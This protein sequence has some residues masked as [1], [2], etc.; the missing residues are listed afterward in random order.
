M[1]LS[2]GC[3]TVDHVREEIDMKHLYWIFPDRGS[4]KQ[5]AQE[6]QY[7]WDEYRV[8]AADAGL[9]LQVVSP[10]AL[11]IYYDG[12]VKAKVFVNNDEV[13]ATDTIFVTELYTF[14]YHQQDTL[15]Q[16]TTFTTLALLG[17]YLPISPDLSVIMN[18]KLATYLFFKG[19]ALPILPSARITTGRDLDN[20]D[21][22]ILLKEIGLPLVIKPA[23]WG[24]GMGI[25][26]AHDMGEVR[27]ILSLAS[28]SEATM[29]IQPFLGS[30][31]VV[32]YRVYFVDG[33]PH[34]YVTRK[35]QAGEIIAN[36]A[37]GGKADIIENIP[38]ELVQTARKAGEMIRLPYFCVDFLF[39]GQTFWLSEV[40][41]DGAIASQYLDKNKVIRLL[42]DRFDAYN[43]SHQIWITKQK[44]EWSLQ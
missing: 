29:L 3:H 40:E 21:L 14:P 32:D 28:G 10:E 20:H 15:V 4:T 43:R 38:Q 37:R 41:L 34:T 24:S 18:D 25:N 2:V 22:T 1:L 16:M 11:S 35:P 23:N 31:Q 13:H 6:Y 12:S 42:H 9:Q 44:N 7:F 5:T 39:D 36:A 8:A 17:F 26:L 30:G 33:V 27:N 19:K